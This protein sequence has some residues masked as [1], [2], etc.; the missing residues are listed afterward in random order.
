[1]VARDAVNT[2][3]R[4]GTATVTAGA[5]CST[6][7]GIASVATETDIPWGLVTLPDG[8]I[9]YSRRDVQEVVR[10][11]PATGA[12]TKV[13][14]V[15][16]AAGTDGEGGLMGLEIAS[17]F[18]SVRRAGQVLSKDDILAGVW[19]FDVEGDPNIVEV[20]IHRLRN[21]SRTCSATRCGTPCLPSPFR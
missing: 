8:S 7:C 19:D 11:D 13:G 18:S 3:A 14:T 12:K 6:V 17:T 2:S 5:G 20:Y 15:P 16:G 1:M 9:L 21:W 10:L 4:S